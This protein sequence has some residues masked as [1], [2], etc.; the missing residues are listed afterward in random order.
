MSRTKH[1]EKEAKKGIGKE[2]WS[3]RLKKHGTLLGRYTKTR[4]HR[5]ERRDSKKIVIK[6]SQ[7]I[8]PMNDNE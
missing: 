5:K 6:E 1:K 8:C 7:C 2:Y 3:S 4:T